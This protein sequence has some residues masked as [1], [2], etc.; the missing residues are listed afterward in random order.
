MSWTWL[1]LQTWSPPPSSVSVKPLRQPLK[2]VACLVEE[3]CC[4][5]R[6]ETQCACG[7]NPF[8]NRPFSCI[9][10]WIVVLL[11]EFW[12]AILPGTVELLCC[13]LN[14]VVSGPY[15]VVFFGL[16][17]EGPSVWLGF[18]SR[19]GNHNGLFRFE[20]FLVIKLHKWSS[21]SGFC[22]GFEVEYRD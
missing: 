1:V 19:N 10:F 14:F 7:D 4:F 13:W 8:G 6:E 18:L 17:I 15:F 2:E 22:L 3:T 20:F 12:V 21:I 11:T 9:L 5:R 16:R